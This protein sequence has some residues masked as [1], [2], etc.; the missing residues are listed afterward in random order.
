VHEDRG[1]RSRSAAALRAE[2]GPTCA[3]PA[4]LAGSIDGTTRMARDAH[5][6]RA[7]FPDAPAASGAGRVGRQIDRDVPHSA[8]E[9]VL[10]AYYVKRLRVILQ[11]TS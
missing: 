2:G 1:V 6:K 10:S 5:E 7:R 8:L 3:S 9:R 11:K 4:P